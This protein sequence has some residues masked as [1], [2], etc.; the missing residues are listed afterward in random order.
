MSGEPM[1]LFKNCDSPPAQVKSIIIHHAL[2]WQRS[3]KEDIK[4]MYGTFALSKALTNKTIP[5]D[6]YL[7]FCRKEYTFSESSCLN[8]NA[9]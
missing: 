3:K 4:G 2:C 8:I 6:I 7:T 9:P 1:R 5:P